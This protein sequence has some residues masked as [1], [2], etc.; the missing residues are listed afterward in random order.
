[1]IR[2]KG[3]NRLWARCLAV[4]STA[5][6][7]LQLS[8]EA[9]SQT[10]LRTRLR[11]R[12]ISISRRM[13]WVR[14][15]LRETKHEQKSACERL[16]EIQARLDSIQ[17]AVERNRVQL[18]RTTAQLEEAK[19]RLREAQKRLEYHTKV[20]SERLLAAQRS[21]D[22]GF[23]SVVLGATDF[24]DLLSRKR[25]VQRVVEAD[26]DL[27]T[28]I[29]RDRAEVERQKAILEQRERQQR[30]VLLEL[31]RRQ[32]EA[33]EAEQE[34]RDTI[35][36]I[37]QNRAELEAMLEQQERDSERVRAMLEELVRSPGGRSRAVRPWTGDYR[38]PV[39][40]SISSRFGMRRHPIL[41]TY[42]MHTGVDI[43][44]AYGS[45]IQASAAGVVVH[46]GW[47]G[48]YGKTVIIDHG[49]GIST[50]YGHCSRLVV[51]Q[52]EHVEQGQTIA[53]VG[54]TG[55]STGPHLHFERRR[56]GVPVNPLP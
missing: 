19:R 49:G 4:A 50:L 17:G 56:D 30:A 43:A 41:G 54:S 44:A 12:L 20:L 51:S 21:P 34:Q 26:V 46:S 16:L 7:L 37:E 35:R 36:E 6:I 15:Q 47:L 33:L 28:A 5:A 53:Y 2:Q 9:A 32:Q 3:A 8:A 42:R 1:M 55:F 52:G 31:A 40:G 25:L 18:A 45:P 38:L 23:I 24:R 22:P 13:T 11:Q 39:R 14:R 48:G 29:E 10:S 27:L